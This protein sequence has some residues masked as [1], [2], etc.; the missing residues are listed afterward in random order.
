MSTGKVR[1]SRMDLKAAR[2]RVGLDQAQL[3][4]AAGLARE[5][6]STFE[7]GKV[8]P[9]EST[10][11]AIQSALEARGIVFTNGDKPGFYVDKTKADI[12]T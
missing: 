6:V 7:N 1:A 2:V 8:P 5:T 3:A 11:E 12:P 4:R 10:R 9:H